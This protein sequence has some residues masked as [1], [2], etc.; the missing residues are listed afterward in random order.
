MQMQTKNHKNIEKKPTKVNNQVFI[1]HRLYVYYLSRSSSKR[2]KFDVVVKDSESGLHRYVRYTLQY[3]AS[4]E[5]ISEK[6]RVF[7]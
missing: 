2:I 5:L 1:P 7:F 3:L 6:M 4:C